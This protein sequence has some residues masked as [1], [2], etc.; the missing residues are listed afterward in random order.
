MVKIKIIIPK[1][2]T[3]GIENGL[4]ELTEFLSKKLKLETGYGLGGQFGYGV[5][6]END[7]FMMHEFCWC[8]QKDCDW[9]SHNKPNFIYKPTNVKI[10]WYKWI[11]RSQEQEGRLPK[12]WLEIC[13]K[14]V[15]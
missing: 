5:D 7:V 6:F 9:C 10:W 11:G 8:D 13:K 1:G 2:A 14:S 3:T 15:K 4:V 12:N